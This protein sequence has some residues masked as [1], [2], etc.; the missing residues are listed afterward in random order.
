MHG[1]S[2]PFHSSRRAELRGEAEARDRALRGDRDAA[3]QRLESELRLQRQEAAHESS[4]LRER[5]EALEA[6]VQR[7][8]KHIMM[9]RKVVLLF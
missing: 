3:V 5:S 9:Y 8:N 7:H 6:E 1:C 4:K 2:V